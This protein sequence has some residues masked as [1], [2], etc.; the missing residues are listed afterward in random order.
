MNMESGKNHVKVR[1]NENFKIL[2]TLFCIS[3]IPILSSKCLSAFKKY[4]ILT[5]GMD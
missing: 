3:E 1:E 2:A 5:L 4:F